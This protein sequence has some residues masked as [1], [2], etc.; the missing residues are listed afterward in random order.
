VSIDCPAQA[1]ERLIHWGSRPAMD[2]DG[3]GE[4]LVARMV[5]QHLLSDVA[6]F[7]DG[8]DEG[9]LAAL[10]TG[11]SYETTT[12]AHK[13]GDAI[14]V[15]PTIARKL[16]EQII[17]SK[18][19]GLARVLFGL[20]IRHVGANVAEVLA[21]H[22]GSIDA[23]ADASPEQIAQIEGIGPKI[24]Q[25]V[26]DFFAVRDNLVVIERLRAAGVVLEQERSGEE[27]P[28]TLAGLTFVLTGTLEHFKR[29]EAGDALKALGA[30]VAGSVS[31]RTS[32]VVAG[33]A[34]G[35]KLA[36]AEELGVPVLDED[37]LAQ[38]LATG[39]VPNADGSKQ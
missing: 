1:Q 10:E 17:A 39:Q 19:R 12:R 37:A 13:A 11:R 15:G 18:S 14:L 35:S 34:A 2:I 28:Q 26:A 23:L 24:A 38:I 8:L 3:L 20:G 32:Y 25:S 33:A 27:Q 6:D 30:K 21:R 7:Y 29:K 9:R 16:M 4:E 5:G 22:F 36:R 31:K